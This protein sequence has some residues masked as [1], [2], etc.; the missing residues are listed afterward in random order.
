MLIYSPFI[1]FAQTTNNSID[2]KAE[3]LKIAQEL[4]D[5][6]LLKQTYEAK[7]KE[8]L[9]KLPQIG[10]PNTTVTPKENYQPEDVVRVIIELDDNF[11]TSNLASLKT[12]INNNLQTD[13]ITDKQTEL[14]NQLKQQKIN[15]QTKHQFKYLLNAISADVKYQDIEKIKRT[16]GVKKVTIANQYYPD[17]IEQTTPDMYFSA[18]LIGAN[19]AW[20]SSYDGDNTI[21]AIVDTGVNYFHPA[22][23]GTGKETLSLGD[24]EDRSLVTGNKAGYTE[25]VIGGYNWADGNNDIVDRTSSQHGVHVTGTAA[26][27]DPSATLQGKPFS[28]V[29][30]KAKILAEKVFSN[31]PDRAS[32]MADEIIA[33]IEHA[34]ANGADVINMSLGATAGAV[35]PDDP[36]LLAVNNA[37][38]AGVV[39]SVS[40]GN[41]AFSTSP[42]APLAE[43]RDYGLV[44]SPSVADGTISVAASVNQAAVF[45]SFTLSS[46]VTSSEFTGELTDV[47][48]MVA[49][50]LPH[51]KT[52]TGEYKIVEVG[53]GDDAGYKDKDVV[54]KVALIERGTYTFSYKIANAFFHGAVAAIIYNRVGASGYISMAV[55]GTEGIPAAFIT[56]E[57]GRA[58]REALKTNPDLTLHFNQDGTILPL[59]VDTMTDFSSWGPEPGLSFKPTLTAPGGNIYSSV[60]DN[61]YAGMSGTSMAA[62]HVTGAAAVVIDYF[63]TKGYNYT[64]NDVKANLSNTS[65]VL[66]DPT[67]NTPYPVLQQGAGRIQVDQAVNNKVLVTNSNGEVGVALKEFNSKS[68]TF[69]LTA[70]NLGD[71]AVTYQ[72][73]GDAYKDKL[74]TSGGYT[75]NSLTLEGITGA[76]VT[77]DQANLT[78]PAK[79]SASVKVTLQL[80]DDLATNQFVEGWITLNGESSNVPNLVVPYFGFYGDWNEPKVIDSHFNDPNSYYGM[81]GL[82]DWDYGFNLGYLADGVT[83]KDQYVAFSPNGDGSQDQ[84]LPVY[85]F[86]RNAQNVEVNILDSAQQKLRTLNLVNDIRKNYG[87]DTYT[88]FTPWDG[89][90]GEQTLPDGQYYIET[91]SKPYGVSAEKKQSLIL[92]VKI[93]TIKPTVNAV[94]QKGDT[95]DKLVITG[96]DESSGTWGY[97]YVV[98]DGTGVVTSNLVRGTDSETGN[99]YEKDLPK[100]TAGSDVFVVAWDNAGNSEVVDVMSGPF[101]YYGGD[102][103][104]DTAIYSMIWYADDSVKDIQVAVDNEAPKSI[105]DH[106]NWRN[107]YDL[108]LPYGKHTIKVTVLGEDSNSEP[109]TIT[110]ITEVAEVN[111][112]SLLVDDTITVSNEEPNV[113]IKFAITSDLIS[114]VSVT[115]E[116]YDSVSGAVYKELTPITVNGQGEYTFT[117]QAPFGTSTLHLDA[118]DG[119]GTSYGKAD[120]VVNSVKEFDVKTEWQYYN[121][122]DETIVPLKI[123]VNKDTY[124]VRLAVYGADNNVISDTYLDFVNTEQTVTQ[125]TYDLD[126]TQYASGYMYN[127]YKLTLIPYDNTGNS[128]NPATATV[129]IIQTGVLK[130]VD[131]GYPYTNKGSFTVKWDYDDEASK[132]KIKELWITVINSSGGTTEPYIIT[133]TNIKEQLIDLSSYQNGQVA[134][135]NINAFDSNYKEIGHIF[136]PIK[137]DTQAP[138]WY[139]DSPEPFALFNA[140]SNLAEI[141]AYTFDMDLDPNSVK[142]FVQGM[143]EPIAVQPINYF[144]FAY[145]VDETVTFKE[146][147][148]QN[149]ELTYSDLLGNKGYH[150]RK[151][152]VDLTSPTIQF[153]NPNINLTQISDEPGEKKYSLKFA[154]YNETFNLQGKVKDSFSSF[155]LYFGDQQILG[156]KPAL[157]YVNSV[158]EREFKQEV[159]LNNGENKFT[160]RAVDGAGNETIVELTITKVEPVSSD[161]GTSTPPATGGTTPTEPKDEGTTTEIATGTVE[162]KE[163][164]GVKVATVTVAEEK[165]AEMITNQAEEVVT[166]DISTAVGTDVNAVNLAFSSSL[167]EKLLEANK[168][169][170]VAGNGYALTLTPELIKELSTA[171]GLKLGIGVE[172]YNK[173]DTIKINSATTSKIVSKLITV[174]GEGE[175]TK[176]ITIKLEYQGATDNRKV[177]GYTLNADGS[178]SK[179]ASVNDWSKDGI[180][181]KIN[182][183]GTKVAAIEYNKRFSDLDNH[184]A[185]EAIEVM[186]AQHVIKGQPDGT[187]NPEGNITRAEFASLLVRMLNLDTSAT[188]NNIFSDV[189]DTDWF[190]KEIKAAYDKGIIT[191]YNGEFNPNAKITREDMMVMLM[192]ALNKEL[193]NKISERYQLFPFADQKEI[194]SYAAQAIEQGI[195]SGLVKGFDGKFAPK[196]FTTRAQAATVLYRIFFN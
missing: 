52:L 183:L 107:G 29:A 25:R 167:V 92:P 174:K 132:E 164:N 172:D 87:T 70:K 114:K 71:T 115:Q 178:F 189:K 96:N 59:A 139:V 55:N 162:V 196:L 184:W 33:A 20:L 187:Y 98:F 192:R 159:K 48:M 116:V 142:L 91:V 155:D 185:Q 129:D 112:L 9:A 130:Y 156:A 5:N 90:V 38:K 47:P 34:V 51:P 175:L 161:S 182:K 21:I 7:S 154:T 60:K 120:I 27:Y 128:L 150:H 80:P 88:F 86:L 57:H 106:D 77:F 136:Y 6:F 13:K 145:I 149:I 79:G 118:V 44:G 103:F 140:K 75:F 15:I 188:Y 74:F 35:T 3:A 143:A 177:S 152:F 195:K 94:I 171:D 95:T 147:G 56:G 4:R 67:T 39:L 84:V 138:A 133:D 148:F 108:P 144:D 122:D 42:Y 62:P 11:V 137:K 123:T 2:H 166:I 93:D 158:D 100:L 24:K 14:L 125:F 179:I 36:E 169:V 186:A 190:A 31:D 45:D 119:N 160:F 73:T 134:N 101:I 110:T 97:S 82:Y 8:G 131:I 17:N 104:S 10:N 117:Y 181:L 18:P 54:G 69:T 50:G 121:L 163:E 72:L 105:A 46:P 193:P 12:L 22:F 28:G 63:K 41:S 151:V 141:F 1:T 127:S 30:P 16:V 43:N 146:E 126:L 99:V 83:Y 65:K 49:D 85:S 168:N 124:Q 135:V 157:Q 89:K 58:I 102:L 176:P 66:I 194:S 173:T 81:T 68:I 19:E 26:G 113:G 64:A 191:G 32:T 170:V 78:V 165:I 61:D 153:T 111:S 180:T 23:G 37:V 76:T 40:S 53:L 109:V